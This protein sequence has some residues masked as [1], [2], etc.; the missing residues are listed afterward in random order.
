MKKIKIPIEISA[1]HIH[2]AKEDFKKLFDKE[3]L[4]FL[5]KLKHNQFSAKETID[6][7]NGDKILKNIRIVGPFRPQTVIEL[8]L[9]DFVYLKLKPNFYI[10]LKNE[11]IKKINKVKILG[12]KGS[13]ETTNVVVHLRH[14][15]IN[16]EKAKKYKLKD[17]Q[18]VSV[19]AKGLRGAILNNVYIRVDKDFDF[20]LHLDT[21]EGNAIGIIKK[22]IGYILK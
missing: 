11:K 20:S 12:P 10:G 6:L 16:P 8:S 3:N 7:K 21:D 17:G 19:E 15:H 22:G 2:I 14:I 1:R 18:K 9:T 13:I 5:K 4:T